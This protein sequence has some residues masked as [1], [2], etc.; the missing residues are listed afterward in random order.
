MTIPPN[1]K[2][3]SQQVSLLSVTLLFAMTLWLS[4]SAVVPQLTEEWGLTEAQQSWMTMSVQIG[5]VVGALTSA[6]FNI[7]DRISP[8]RLI[9]ASAFLGAGFNIAIPYFVTQ[10]NTA[11]FLRFLTG[12]TMAGI[13]PP[14]MKAVSS[15]MKERR[16]FGIG[17]LVGALTFGTALPHLLNAIPL[18][19]SAGMPPW[20]TVLITTSGLALIAGLIALFLLKVGPH[21][22]KSAPFNWRFILEAFKDRPTRLANFGYL[23]HM[24][25]LY[26]MW[27]WVPIL[28]IYS[29]EQSGLT[30]QAA[31][32]AGFG[33]VA[34]GSVGSILAGV[35]ADKLGRTRITIISMAI[36]GGIALIIGYFIPY[37]VVLTILCLIWGFAVVADSAQFS[38][39]VSELADTQYIGTAL[40]VQTSAGFLLTL[41]TIR[42][43]PPLVNLIGWKFAFAFLALGPAF[44]II[45]MAKL[46]QLPQA[47]QLASGNK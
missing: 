13:Y 17:L 29:Y 18:F 23:G 31:R 42:L 44:G 33:V 41:F 22:S 3:K 8:P 15:W 36:S 10:P 20:R 5:F 21:L 24:W 35:L 45:S 11:L 26:A 46:R 9:A 2:I 6:I 32:L 16:G 37:P 47:S 12:I 34:I 38:A 4:A 7:A 30:Q 1:S 19:G 28:L 27:A 40:T 14:G 43:I 25:E 39:A